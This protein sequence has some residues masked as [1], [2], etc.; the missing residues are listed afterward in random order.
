MMKTAEATGA[1]ASHPPET[2]VES[3]TGMLWNVM[4]NCFTGVIQLK[5]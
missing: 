4:F 3:P 2:L 1:Q 5:L